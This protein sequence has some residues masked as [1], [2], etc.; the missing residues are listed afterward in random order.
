M[1]TAWLPP[2]NFFFVILVTCSVGEENQTFTLGVIGPFS[3]L[4]VT[5][6]A[7]VYVG[8]QEVSE[9]HLLDGYHINLKFKDSRCDK[10]VGTK[11]VVEMW[12]SEGS[13]DAVIGDGCS[14]VCNPVGLLTA[15]WNIPQVSFSC[16]HPQLSDKTVY[17]TFTRTVGPYDQIIDVTMDFL[18]LFGWNHLAIIS[19]TSEV[20][21]TLSENMKDRL[22]HRGMY[23]RY[24]VLDSI[25]EGNEVVEEKL[26]IQQ[27]IVNDIKYEARV[28]FLQMYM[29][30]LRN[31][32]ITCYEEGLMNGEYVFLGYESAYYPDVQMV[33]RPELTDTILKQGLIAILADDVTGATWDKFTA[34]INNVVKSGQLD[35]IQLSAE[36]KGSITAVTGKLRTRF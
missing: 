20:L 8:I 16:A 23:V 4:G 2:I 35:K 27:G 30:D 18:E 1:H 10:L 15:A 6:L 5:S 25:L 12:S 13:I 32:L 11:A 26:A 33:Y 17:P 28:V 29:S 14:D 21:V 24:H 36:T 34:D 22:E 19:G 31:F 9:R 3:I 7:A